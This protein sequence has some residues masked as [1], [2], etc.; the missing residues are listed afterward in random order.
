M[1][2]CVNIQFLLHRSP[3]PN[4][5]KTLWGTAMANKNTLTNIHTHNHYTTATNNSICL[6]PDITPLFAALKEE[7]LFP[8]FS[9]EMDFISVVC[10]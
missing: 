6:P 4:M 9:R 7:R 1:Y 2:V 8:R 10:L 5:G 3:G